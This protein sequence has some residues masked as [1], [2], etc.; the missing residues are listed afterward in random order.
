VT[1]ACVVF[2]GEEGCLLPVESY[3]S[4][5]VSFTQGCKQILKLLVLRYYYR[6]VWRPET[7]LCL[8]HIGELAS[9]M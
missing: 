7:S 9:A 8:L 3:I 6:L 1:F 4:V 2:V 5:F